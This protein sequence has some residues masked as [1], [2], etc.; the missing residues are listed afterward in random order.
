LT[1]TNPGAVLGLIAVFGGIST[2][3]EV[4]STIDVLLLVAAIVAGSM[5]W[6]ITLSHVIGR[7]RHQID[8]RTLQ[9]INRIAGLLLGVFGAVLIGEVIW[10][11]GRF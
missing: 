6:W 11:G 7:Y 3:V 2:F 5:L 1:I 10:K 8:M 9:T 4:H